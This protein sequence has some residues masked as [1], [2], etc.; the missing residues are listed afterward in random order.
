MKHVYIIAEVGVNH[1]GNTKIAKELV[2]VA[3]E[4]GADAVKFQTFVPSNLVTKNAHKAE[5]QK[6]TDNNDDSQ[7]DMLKR[8]ALT[9]DDHYELVEYCNSKDIQFLSTPFDIESIDFLGALDLPL[10]KISSG[11]ITNLPYLEHIGGLCSPIILSTGMS[12]MDEIKKAVNILK[13]SGCPKISVLHCN[14]EYPTPYEDV[15]LKA[16][17]CL[18]EELD[19]DIGYSDHTLGIEVP[20]AAV[21]MG[22]TIIEKHITLDRGMQGPD[23]RASIEPYEFKLMVRAIRNIEKAIGEKNK[24]VSPS[25]KKNIEIVRK[26]IVAK[27]NIK[28]G[29]VFSEKNITVKRPGTGISPMKWYDVIGRRAVREYSEDELIEL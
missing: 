19:V 24:K 28:K 18:R 8:L 23:H 20:I 17:V 22:A 9:K 15:N 21:A 11:D 29:E 6:N 7:L 3:K 16:M 13:N 12:S 2:D 25:E 4:A 1:N 14:T 26:S 5:Y 27:K 10:Y